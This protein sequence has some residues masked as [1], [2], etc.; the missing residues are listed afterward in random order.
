M[1]HVDVNGTA[2]PAIGLGTWQAKGEECSEAVRKALNLGYRHIDTA[3]AYENERAVG[4][5]IKESDVERG[6]I[7]LTTKVW[8]DRLEPK[9]LKDSVDES[10][11]K[12]G[13]DYVDLLLIHWPF[14]DL[15]LEGALEKM[16]ELVDKGKVKNIGVSNF[17]AAQI[18]KSQKLSEANLMTNQVEYHPF[19]DQEKVLEKCRE[20]EM[21]LTAYSPLS[22]GD[23]MGDET[24]KSIGDKYGKT[25]AQVA[26][27]WL[28]QQNDVVAIPK[29][30]S[31]KHIKD[32]L[33]IFDFK[34]TEDEME[35]IHELKGDARK[36]NP[37]FAPEWD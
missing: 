10:L 21:M 22:R 24:L 12:L 30:T 14:P 16:N 4:K 25:E 35:K 7:F 8:R 32:N 3:Q 37:G 33:E 23:V 17:T 9:K 28:V 15:D 13:T 18:D 1:K 34:L 31:F 29:A 36:V 11:E 26:L 6:E 5:G 20:H 19:L 27:R 2:V